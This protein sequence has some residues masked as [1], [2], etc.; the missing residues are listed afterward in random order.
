[1]ADIISRYNYSPR[2]RQTVTP[3]FPQAA[4]SAQNAYLASLDKFVN[5]GGKLAETYF[6]AIEKRN[7]RDA[8]T[9]A[10]K[11]LR[12]RYINTVQ[13]VKGKDTDE[14]INREDDWRKN[15]LDAF[16]KRNK[17]DSGIGR[18]IWAKASE[19]YLNRIG[20]YQLSEQAAY[21]KS[22]KL[23][24]SNEMLNELPASKI[25]DMNVLQA[26]FDKNKEL[27]KDDPHL[28]DR[29]N[30]MVVQTAMKG[31]ARQNPQA[32]LSWFDSHRNELMTKFGK[33]F[34]NADAVMDQTKRRLQADAQHAEA[35]AARA[36]RLQEKRE[37]MY[38][39]QQMNGLTTKLINGSATA[40][41][42]NSFVDDPR[43]SA[44]NKLQ[45]FNVVKGLEA[46]EEHRSNAQAKAIQAATEVDIQGKIYDGGYTEDVQKS[47]QKAM[48][49]GQ[50]TA[51]Q[52][53]ALA[54]EGE[55]VNK[56]EITEG[57]PMVK[58]TRDAIKRIYTPS[59]G[60]FG[61]GL[62]PDQQRQ[63]IAINNAITNRLNESPKTI[64]QDFNLLDSNSWINNLLR[65]NAPVMPSMSDKFSGFNVNN[66]FTINAPGKAPTMPT[67]QPG[68]SAAD[69]LKRTREGK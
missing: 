7:A 69:F 18:E 60:L 67:R 64:V 21:D 17:V 1:M 54:H 43:V 38:S 55:R 65:N 58:D 68:Q 8:E 5:A 23:S 41:D 11:T 62:T 46:A 14:L 44:S 36:Q 45:A 49:D 9:D 29:Q 28:A 63:Y 26:A 12:E 57:N 50:L 53:R 31:W 4:I 20:S 6:N 33:V 47:M 10:A 40:V 19:G 25:G 52:A 3:S 61:P 66:P 51:S 35:M 37:R 59:S 32:A 27:F 16:L 56:S 42:F 15:E 24:A 13:T 22:S 48:A 34:I 39:E 2:E 30:D